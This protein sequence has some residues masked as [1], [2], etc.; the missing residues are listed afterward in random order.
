MPKGNHN[1]VL[2][3]R[4][5]DEN[6]RLKIVSN[7]FP[8][9][10]IQSATDCLRPDR[11]MNQFRRL[12]LDSTQSLGPVEGFEPTFSSFNSLNTNE[13]DD[14]LT[15]L[16]DDDDDDVIT[17]DDENN[18]ICEIN[19]H[20]DHYRLCKEKAAHDAVLGKIDD[21]IAKK[22]LTATEAPHLDTQSLIPK[23]RWCC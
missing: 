17:D 4:N 19:T 15:E 8:T 5:D 18:L 6:F 1:K 9:A 3:L 13:D 10:T 12:C 16:H 11:L 2:R 22:Q 14:A 7:E 23:T 20:A 21:S